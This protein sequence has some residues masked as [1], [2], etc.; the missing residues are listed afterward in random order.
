LI[1]EFLEK[2]GDDIHDMLCE[3][4]LGEDYHGLDRGR[5]TEEEVE[6]AI[7]FCPEVLR[8]RKEIVWYIPEDGD[9]DDSDDLDYQ[10]FLAVF[11]VPLLA[12]LAI[13]FRCFDEV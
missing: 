12:R 1:K 8:R 9:D 3:S 11:F 13:E 6:T 10:L 5:D 2:L 7:R 4:E